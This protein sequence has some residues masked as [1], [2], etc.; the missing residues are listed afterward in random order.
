MLHDFLS[1]AVE[2]IGLQLADF[3]L[4]VPLLLDELIKF[5][6]VVAAAAAEVA[7]PFEVEPLFFRLLFF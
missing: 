3:S 5:A 6:A 7:P 1:L 4:L 2:P